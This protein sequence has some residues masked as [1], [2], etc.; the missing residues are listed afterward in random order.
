MYLG[1]YGS[2]ENQ[3]RVQTIEEDDKIIFSIPEGLRPNE[4]AT[5]EL[6]LEQGS[7]AA[8]TFF[9]KKSSLL[10]LALGG[11][12]MLFYFFITWLKY[13]ILAQ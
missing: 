13:V 10:T 1:A 8:P 2:G 4:A 3:S 6:N 9:E 12:A 7:V 5:V 11:L